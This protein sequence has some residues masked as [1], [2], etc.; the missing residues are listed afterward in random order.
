MNKS[1]HRRLTTNFIV[2]IVLFL[3]LNLLISYFI[4][5]DYYVSE[6]KENLTHQ[7][8]L[9]ADII[10]STYIEDDD[11]YLQ[12]ISNK[13]ARDTGLRVTVIDAA[14]GNVMADSGFDS[15]IMEPHKSRPEIFK[16][17]KGESGTDIRFSDTAGQ[18]LLYAAIPFKTDTFSGVLRLAKP[19]KEIQNVLLKIMLLLL[20][21]IV[22]TGIAAFIIS[23]TIARRLA[24]PLAEITES[25]ED[26]ARGNFS[27]RITAQFKDHE[28]EGLSAAVNNMAEYI[29]DYL[30]LT[31]EVKSQLEAL[32]ENTVNGILMVDLS[33]RIKY[34]NPV[35]KELLFADKDPLGRKHA[36]V[37]NNYELIEIIDR[38]R[39]K[40]DLI[41]TKIK[42]YCLGEKIIDVNALMISTAKGKQND[43]I[44][45][46][47]NDITGITHLEQ[48]RKDFVANVTHELKTP[49]ASI[50]GFAET[51]LSGKVDDKEEFRE[52]SQII[53][54][55]TQR[56]T[57]LINDLFELSRIEN[58]VEQ[59]SRQEVDIGAVIED[60]VKLILKKPE[61]ADHR[62][63][64]V[65]PSQPVVILT[66]HNSI[67]QIMINLL[68]NAVKFSD[69]KEDIRI[70]LEEKPEEIIVSV[71]DKGEGI[72]EKEQGRVFER[73]YRVDQARSRKTGGTGLG[74][75]IVKHLAERLGGRAGVESKPGE[76]S[77]F[78]FSIPRQS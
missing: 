52:F 2:T 18:Y 37:I 10:S 49:L 45:V 46:V 5:K 3:C 50:S 53:Y 33:G 17:L 66:E 20:L 7:A 75:S 6:I 13:I 72:P 51:M 4:F 43:S 34:V 36:D 31:T 21:T 59:V 76:G 44:L 47:L 48:V 8:Y 54:N 15:H 78:Y 38:L 77:R 60:T 64:F 74:L 35:A 19:L 29:E 9:A 61:A 42:L 22:L 69:P 26:I 12:Q 57:A 24:L 68:D 25:V 55:E 32:L 14:D 39:N 23:S 70:V 41:K 65:R 73:F 71:I 28:F 62:I 56:L 1:F 30:H 27:R 11:N 63:H 40:A 58:A 67:V 16:A